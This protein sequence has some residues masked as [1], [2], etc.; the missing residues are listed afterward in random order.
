MNLLQIVMQLED[1]CKSSAQTAQNTNFDFW[2]NDFSLI[3]LSGLLLSIIG[4]LLSVFIFQSQ[5]K[6]E[7]NTRKLSRESQYSLL[8]D[9][10]RHLYRNLVITY[11]VYSKMKIHHFNGYPSEEHFMKLKVP[12]ENIHL[13]AFYGLDKEYMAL[14][15]LYLKMRN[16]NIEIDIAC[17]HM[18][19]SHL[20]ESVRKRDFETL[21]FKAQFIVEIIIKTIKV[22][23]TE[24]NCLS[25]IRAT[26]AEAQQGATNSSANEA[27]DISGY[28]PFRNDKSCYSQIIYLDKK[29]QDDFYEK[30]NNDIKTELGFNLQDSSKIE[31]IDF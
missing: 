25:D 26:L 3:A 29:G 27:G 22:V 16:Y 18:K 14:H 2:S 28:E 31:I 15:N 11:A 24:K 17:E 30:L 6:T 20:K 21:L 13:E 8:L 23:W 19:N 1:L 10:T 4:L 12:M 7:G 9:L 5:K